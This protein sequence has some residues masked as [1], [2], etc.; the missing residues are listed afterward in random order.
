MRTNA[1]TRDSRWR[2]NRKRKEQRSNHE[3]SSTGYLSHKVSEQADRSR[4][5]QR[6]VVFVHVT[7]HLVFDDTSGIAQ[8][9][10]SS[11]RKN[12]GRATI[13]F[14][15]FAASGLFLAADLWSAV[16]WD[17]PFRMLLIF[18][19]LAVSWFWMAAFTHA[20]AGLA[21][22]EG[23][24]M[25]VVKKTF[26]MAMRNGV[27]TMFIIILNVLP[28]V[29]LARRFASNSFGQWLITYLL[30][31]SG[32]VAYLA[33]LHLARLFAPEKMEKMMEEKEE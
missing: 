6:A 9:F 25:A 5:R 1:L 13:V 21:W 30:I 4:H 17:T 28:I 15:A 11:F 23:K 8:T 22:F 7:L 16:N 29:F 31:G 14:L 24:P 26:L 18:M 33:S 32:A 12:F 10:F 20:F 2:R 27:Y 19:I 3:I